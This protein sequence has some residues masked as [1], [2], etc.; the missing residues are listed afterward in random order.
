MYVNFII[1]CRICVEPHEKKDN[2]LHASKIAISKK[3]KKR[4]T[5]KMDF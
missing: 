3:L 4:P 5:T 2:P 1:M